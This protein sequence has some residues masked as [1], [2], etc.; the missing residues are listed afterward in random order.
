VEV[1]SGWIEPVINLMDRDVTIAACQPKVKAYQQKSYFEH[2]GAAGGYIDQLGYP[3]CRGR[4]IDITEEDRGQYD[5]IVPIFWATGACFFVRTQVYR[6]M[7]GF[8]AS[9]FAHMEEIDLCWR[10]QR[11][12]YKLYC[13]P[14]SVVYHVGGGT[15]PATNP[16]KTYLNFRNSSVMLY[17]NEP[18]SGLLWKLPAK[19]GIDL[20]AMLYFQIKG[21][22]QDRRAVWKATID[23]LSKIGHWKRS[24]SRKLRANFSVSFVVMKRLLVWERYFRGKKHFR[25]LSFAGRFSS[26][27]WDF[28]FSSDDDEGSSKKQYLDTKG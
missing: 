25:E 28:D 9:F 15:M 14:Q 19:L 3:F 12:G 18:L 4:I 22:S 27:K 23:F 5:N 7:G 21:K 26:T 11:T 8:D 6:S 20:L 24:D 1:T 16:R 2:A 10:L 17:K 13:Q